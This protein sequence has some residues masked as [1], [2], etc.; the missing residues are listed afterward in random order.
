LTFDEAMRDADCDGFRTAMGVE[1]TSL[2]REG[3]W[4]KVPKQEALDKA[5][6]I[7]PGT[8]AFKCKRHPEGYVTHLKA[9]YCVRGDL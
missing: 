3:T 6:R 1:I 9:R 8:W 4:T 5:E 2:E 7:L